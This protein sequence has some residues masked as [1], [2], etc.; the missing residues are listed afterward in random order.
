MK[1]FHSLP[2]ALKFRNGCPLCSN[3][4]QINDRNLI[5]STVNYDR[6]SDS[7]HHL[8]TLRV[9]Q[10]GERKIT[11]NVTTG[12][13]ERYEEP[14]PDEPYYGIPGS[15]TARILSGPAYSGTFIHAL[16]VDCMVCFQYG[17]ALQLYFEISKT[18]K[19]STIYLNS[20]YINIE[21]GPAVHKIKNSYASSETYYSYFDRAA[22]TKTATLPIIPLNI[23]KPK[24][25]LHRIRKLLPFS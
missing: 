3:N 2:T 20:E 25:T 10:Y 21:D 16:S 13:I 22:A 15:L 8:I 1:T 4:L 12:E 18:A 5:D 9:D 14:L 17:F 11:L 24:E 6:S 7:F 19:L 23:E